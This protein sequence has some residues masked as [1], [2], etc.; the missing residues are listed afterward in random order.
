[1]YNRLRDGAYD[2]EFDFAWDTRLVFQNCMLYN[3]K[4]SELYLSA[5]NLL[6]FFDYL[7]CYW[8]YNV[9]DYRLGKY[10]FCMYIYIYYCSI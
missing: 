10:M 3:D 6:L 7:L 1:M 5:E 8:V 4:G 9:Q 2:N